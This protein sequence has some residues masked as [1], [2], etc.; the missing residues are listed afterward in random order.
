MSMSK[1]H[2]SCMRS[3]LALMDC[4]LLKGGRSV[5]DSCVQTCKVDLLKRLLAALSRITACAAA[6]KFKRISRELSWVLSD[7]RRCDSTRHCSASKFKRSRTTFVLLLRSSKTFWISSAVS[8]FHLWG[9][10]DRR[11]SELCSSR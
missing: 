9:L 7:R 2:G 1:C 4:I 11:T 5:R 3:D 8:M 10:S 6:E